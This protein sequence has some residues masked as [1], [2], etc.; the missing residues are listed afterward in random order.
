MRY[1]VLAVLAA[2]PALAQTDLLPDIIVRESDLYDNDISTS[3]VA[4][5]THLRLSNGTA[6]IGAGKLHLYGGAILPNDRREVFQR[7][8]RDDGSWYDRLAGTFVHHPTHGHIH[9]EDWALYSLREVLPGDGVG[10]VIAKGLKTSFCIIDL[11]VYDSSLPGF[12]PGGEFNSCGTATQGLS[13]GWIDVYSKGLPGQNIDITGVPDGVYWLESTVDPGN[14]VLESDETNNV[15]RIKVTIGTPNPIIADAFEPNDSIGDVVSRPEGGPNSPNLGPTG[16]LTTLSN[17]TIETAGDSDFYRFY[18]PAPGTGSDFVRID[19][20]NGQ[21]D[22]DMR[23]RDA[24]GAVLATSDTT[25]DQELISLSGRPAGWYFAEAF[26]FNGATSPGYTLTIDPSANAA[27]TVAVT[28]PALGN[29][30]REHGVENYT[31]NWLASDPES[32]QTWVSVYANTT[33]TLDGNELLIPTSLHTPGAQGFYVINSAELPHGR[34]WFYAEITDGGSTSGA[35]SSG[36]LTFNECPGDITTTG[37]GEGDPGFGQP[38]DQVSAADLNLYVNWW[39]TTDPG[40][41]VTTTGAGAGDPGSGVPD[42]LITASDINYFVQLW[43]V[44]CP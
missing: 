5:R 7:V 8:Y 33:P 17:L 27:P 15:A 19:F 12:I 26:G 39:V 37:A 28:D 36:T 3:V 1:A 16:P 13:I 29:A 23:L 40:A 18:M 11:G 24:A 38:D 31:L 41:D 34:F 2:T 9:F 32:N 42:G 44:G 35:W 14:D 4:G 10:P 6:N 21:G 20:V 25:S 22:L 30:L 43:V